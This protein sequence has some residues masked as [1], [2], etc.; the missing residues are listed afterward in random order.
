MAAPTTSRKNG[1]SVERS[2]RSST[3]WTA[4]AIASVAAPSRTFPPKTSVAPAA[5]TAGAMNAVTRPY[6]EA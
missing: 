5:D 1:G 3:G 2:S 4:R 6:G